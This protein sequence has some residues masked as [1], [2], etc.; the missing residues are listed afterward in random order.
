MADLLLR[1][2][3]SG[4]SVFD[5]WSKFQILIQQGRTPEGIRWVFHSLCL[6]IPL[7]ILKSMERGFKLILKFST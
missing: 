2:D 6:A 5:K 7:E 3:D 1:A 4:K